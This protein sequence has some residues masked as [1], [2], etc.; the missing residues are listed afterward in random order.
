MTVDAPR[1]PPVVFL[2]D[3][4]N[5]LLDNDR[6]REDFQTH[7]GERYGDEARDRYWAIQ[8]QL[9]VDLGYRDYLGA[10]Q[11][12]RDER[13]EHIEL[14]A[15]SSWLVDF[16]F[17][18]RLYPR[19]LDVLLHLGRFGPT[20]ILSDGDVVFQPRKVERSGIGAAVE[21]RVLIYIHK[22]QS[23]ADVERRHP[24]E[25][26]VIVDDKPRILAAVKAHWGERVT[27][28]LP[29]QGQFACAPGDAAAD[30]VIDGIADLLSFDLPALTGGRPTPSPEK[31]PA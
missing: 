4:D 8:E 22:E 20:V 15:M 23:L 17:A 21:G 24:A 10:L 30:I 13:P 12:Y 7:L 5:T 31:A 2:V 9:F 29:R 1:K 19:A 28:V 25:R 16:R 27:T 18:D 26:Y 14:L 3:V 11:R 6:I